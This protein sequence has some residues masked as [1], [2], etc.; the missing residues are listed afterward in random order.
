MHLRPI[1]ISVWL[2]S[3]PLFTPGIIPLDI[4]QFIH[5]ASLEGDLGCFQLFMI[6]NK[7]VANILQAEMVMQF[8]GRV[9]PNMLKALAPL[10]NATKNNS[11]AQAR[12][13]VGINFV[14]VG[15]VPQ[16]TTAGSCSNS[17]STFSSL[18]NCQTAVHRGSTSLHSHQLQGSRLFRIPFSNWHCEI[19]FQF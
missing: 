14:S 3:S 6:T 11:N 17:K 18:W 4:S 5:S 12:F 13:C 15:E 8:S 2:D 10:P 16:S 1:N 9:M 7:V 19:D